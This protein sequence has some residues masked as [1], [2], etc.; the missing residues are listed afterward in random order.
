MTR[1]VVRTVVTVRVIYTV[2]A[3]LVERMTVVVPGMAIMKVND[4]IFGGDTSTISIPSYFTAHNK[5]LHQINTNKLFPIQ[6]TILF[7]FSNYKQ[8]KSL[9]NFLYCNIH[10]SD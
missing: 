1:P 8:F 7:N 10:C 9:L 5:L 4:Q 2:V 6:Q 3:R